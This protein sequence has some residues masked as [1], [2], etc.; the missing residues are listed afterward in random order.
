MRKPLKPQPGKR[1][2]GF[3]RYKRSE[4]ARLLRGAMD[5]G[6]TVRGF[7]VDPITGRLR[8]LVG[9]SDDAQQVNPWDVELQHMQKA[10]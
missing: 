8:V 6:L 2:R 1:R 5:A 10:K 4:T 9:E 3:T 7:E